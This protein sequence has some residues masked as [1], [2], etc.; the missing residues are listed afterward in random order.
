MGIASTALL[1]EGRMMACDI[2]AEK[3]NLTEVN[4][5]L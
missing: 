3:A 1:L 2:S 5:S 4:E